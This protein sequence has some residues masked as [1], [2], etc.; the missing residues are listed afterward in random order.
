MVDITVDEKLPRSEADDL[1]GRHPAIGATDSE[2]F[3]PLDL[4]QTFEIFRIPALDFGG[5]L[6]IVVKKM[7]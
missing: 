2:I 6:A 5:P 1:V 4:A 7:G 3:W